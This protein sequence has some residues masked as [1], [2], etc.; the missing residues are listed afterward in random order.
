MGFYRLDAPRAAFGFKKI[1]NQYNRQT[2]ACYPCILGTALSH[3]REAEKRTDPKRDAKNWEEVRNVIASVSHNL[4]TKN[5]QKLDYK[6]SVS[7]L[8]Q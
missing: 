4:E 5:A 8:K 1:A 7:D 2:Q 3:Y 6:K